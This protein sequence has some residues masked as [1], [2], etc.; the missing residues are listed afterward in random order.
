MVLTQSQLFA[1]CQEQVVWEASDE[2]QKTL[3]SCYRCVK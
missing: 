3:T 2:L 1:G